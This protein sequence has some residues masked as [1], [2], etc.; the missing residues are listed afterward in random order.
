MF[1]DDKDTRNGLHEKQNVYEVFFLF[2]FFI[3]KTHDMRWKNLNLVFDENA[4]FSIYGHSKYF[5][6]GDFFKA[7]K[8]YIFLQ[9]NIK[10]Y[11]F[12]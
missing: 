1:L 12:R 2:L 10:L 11:I 9:L 6:F 3:S 4:T 7:N 5:R 8:L